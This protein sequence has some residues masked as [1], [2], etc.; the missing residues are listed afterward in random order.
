MSNLKQ[1]GDE[2][3]KFNHVQFND[4]MLDD[5]NFDNDKLD[6]IVQAKPKPST[7]EALKL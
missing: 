2:E 5:F 7:Q 3:T 4:S 6:K 1:F